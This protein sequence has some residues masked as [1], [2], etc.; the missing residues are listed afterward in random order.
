[1]T[2][3]PEG[4]AP[5][6]PGEATR[7]LADLLE[8]LAGS[9]TEAG[10]Q[11]ALTAAQAALDRADPGGDPALLRASVTG[12][13]LGLAHRQR[14]EGELHQLLRTAQRLLDTAA[15]D[16]L[17]SVIVQATADLV[18]GDVAHL[19]LDDEQ[20]GFETI[21]A[22]TGARTEAF[23]RQ[24]TPPGAGLTGLVMRTRSTYVTADYLHDTALEHD[25][26]GDAAIAADR[27]VTMAAAPMLHG[28]TA[29][30]VL[31]VSWRTRTDVTEDQLDLLTSLASLAGVAVSNA[32]L[33]AQTRR[34]REELELANEHLEWSAMAHDRLHA[35]LLPGADVRAVADT[36]HELLHAP[37]AVLDPE[38]AMLAG[39]PDPWPVTVPREALHQAAEHGRIT[40]FRTQDN[41]DPDVLWVSPA[42]AGHELLGVVVV[43]KPVLNAA[44]QRT[45]ERAATTGALLLS[46]QQALAQAEFQSATDAIA[47]LTRG[48][49][50]AA[51]T[52]RLR[53][54]GTDLSAPHCILVTGPLPD[55][56]R[57]ARTLAQRHA[58]DHHG[59]SGDVDGRLV[60]L[61]PTEDPDIAARQLADRLAAAGL[62][63]SVG[64]AGPFTGPHALHEHYREALTCATA[65]HQLAGGGAATARTLGFLGLLLSGTSRPEIT[66]YV[67]D[68]LAPLQ[69]HDARHGTDLLPTLASYL[70]R[71]G[72]LRRTA[73]HL[74]IH[75]NTVLQRLKRA[76][77]LLG[78]DLHAP[79]TAAELH[80]ALRVSTLLATSNEP[81][82]GQAP[83]E[84]PTRE[85]RPGS[86]GDTPPGRHP[87]P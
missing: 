69:R 63:V 20:G 38:G 18:R 36:V 8:L 64:A 81:R 78:I 51:A 44:E 2:P 26:S 24:H 62:L 21:R 66:R 45:V 29:I 12:L 71:N 52:Q 85:R 58:Q 22:S 9:G 82:Q 40:R 70:D 32:R 46:S 6:A 37:T 34:A 39:A 13:R 14:R 65:Q 74:H 73:E 35:L 31:I 3:E 4:P 15:P 57:R 11:K 19:N 33:H 42:Y 16:H 48:A 28:D 80:L 67:Q 72:S 23:R 77:R 53:T 68:T 87:P 17:L 10:V 75:P 61:L 49:H 43:G 54:M 47:D 60:S 59:R 76:E 55:E 5:A 86:T 1:M 84:T 7:R 56:R 41:D 83:T 27:L 30:G 50:V 79:G 25:P